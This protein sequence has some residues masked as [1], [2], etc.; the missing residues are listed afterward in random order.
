MDPVPLP[1]LPPVSDPPY[2]ITDL[3]AAVVVI[4]G[5]LLDVA[6]A[7]G[8]L[9]LDPALRAELLIA[10]Q[11][12]LAVLIGFVLAHR[13][14]KYMATARYVAT[15]HSADPQLRGGVGW[16]GVPTPPTQTGTPPRPSRPLL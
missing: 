11:P 3:A 15:L 13:G 9:H 6:T 1:P 2:S 10:L 5:L 14:V 12:S 4:L 16:S 8:W 7:A